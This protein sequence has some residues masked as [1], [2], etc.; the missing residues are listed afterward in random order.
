MKKN[1]TKYSWLL[2]PIL[3][4]LMLTQASCSN[5]IAENTSDPVPGGTYLTIVTRGI[6]TT[7]DSEYEDY[8]KTLRVIAFKNGV[9]NPVLNVLLDEEDLPD[10]NNNGTADNTDDDFVDLTNQAEK[11]AISSGG[12][13][14]TFYFIANEEGHYTTD[15]TTT[16][17]SVLKAENITADDLESMKV[18]FT[19]AEFSVPT[20]LKM[21]MSTKMSLYIK[22][23][24]DRTIT[25]YL[26]RALAK[27]QLALKD[28][29]GKTS[30]YT[31]DAKIAMDQKIPNSYY[32]MSGK[33]TP[34]TFYLTLSKDIALS[35]GEDVFDED[36]KD[37][38]FY[39]SKPVYLPERYLADND[40]TEDNALKYSITIDGNNYT[41]P[42][43]DGKNAPKIDY[44]IIR[45]NA[46][47]TIGTYD[48]A[49]EVTVSFDWHV[50]NYTSIT[51][52]V[53]SFN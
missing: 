25:I 22:E 10:Q 2:T 43:A 33:T 9:T 52:N 38:Y 49:S 4:C 44:K 8:V 11:F 39:V 53:P 34:I 30:G 51:V 27:A 15:G 5:D 46:Y 20:E 1:K 48:P 37:N 31:V 45:N 6:N 35:A 28:K 17:E 3:A 18:Q 47:T 40:N 13:S 12:G 36:L 23:G 7:D 24:E 42:I 41:A 21:L 19:E 16:L 14:Y 50:V 29:E 26:D 32:L